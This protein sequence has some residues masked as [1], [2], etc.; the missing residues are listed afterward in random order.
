MSAACVGSSLRSIWCRSCRH[1]CGIFLRRLAWH[2]HMTSSTAACSSPGHVMWW[3]PCLT[4][5]LH[6]LV[7]VCDVTSTVSLTC[8]GARTDG[9][10]LVA[11]V[12][13]AFCSRTPGVMA[14]VLCSAWAATLPITCP[15]PTCRFLHIS[16]ISLPSLPVFL[17]PPIWPVT[18]FRV[19]VCVRPVSA[20]RQRR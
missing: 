10:M 4:L 3:A 20:Q 13:G 15:S 6:V 14:V 2:G 7:C 1:C 12:L 19:C 5:L 17:S 9:K 11:G 18:V 8:R 16:P